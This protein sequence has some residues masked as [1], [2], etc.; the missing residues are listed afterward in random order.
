L[1]CG[2]RT[3]LSPFPGSDHLTRSDIISLFIAK[4]VEN[5]EKPEEQKL[6]A[7]TTGL[8]SFLSVLCGESF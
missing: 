4:D 1:P 8:A 7:K 5:A 6:N 3:F 2:A